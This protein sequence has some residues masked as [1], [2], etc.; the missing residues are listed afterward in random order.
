[1]AEMSDADVFGT[2]SSGS[3]PRM[4]NDAE[5][6]GPAPPVPMSD[7]AVGLSS[8]PGY[9]DYLGEVGKS[10]ARGVVEAAVASP[11]RGYAGMHTEEALRAPAERQIAL[12]QLMAGRDIDE[13]VV[14][15]R[16]TAQ[17][18][19]ATEHPLY[20]TA[21]T[22]SG[23]LPK[24]KG[25]LNP[26]VRDVASGFGSVAGNIG[27]MMIPGYNLLGIP[28]VVAQGAGEA[29]ERAVKANAT[30]EQIQRAASFGNI[31]GATEFADALLINSG[32]WGRAASLVGRVGMRALKGAFIEGGQEGLQQFIQNVIAQQIYKPEQKWSEDVAYNAMIG[33]IVGG[34]VAAPGLGGQTPQTPVSQPTAID[35][36][37]PPGLDPRMPQPGA[38][39][40]TM[41][42]AG[43]PI[44]PP[45][46]IPLTPTAEEVKTQ[47]L[48]PEIVIHIQEEALKVPSPQ[49]LPD[50]DKLI[51]RQ[52]EDA[53]LG[54]EP[55]MARVQ[56]SPGANTARLAKLLGPKLYG[57]PSNITAVS[58]KEMFQ[59]SFDAVKASLEGKALTDGKID[60]TMDRT[61][62]SIGITD[63]GAGM[64]PEVL[65]NQFLQIA[66]TH[67]E[68]KRASGGLGI[69]KMLFI[70]GNKNLHVTT[71]RN[72]T[73]SELNT[74]G[75]EL[76]SALDD[77]KKAPQ[78]T[79][80]KPTSQD[81]LL[82]PNGHGT[83]VEVT[84]PSKYLDS[85]TGEDKEIGF[86][87][88]SFQH[89]VLK[90]SPLFDNID[91]T[92]NGE[93][94][95]MGK[96]FPIED[97]TQF[98]NVKFDWGTA[99]IYVSQKSSANKYQENV[100]V[101]SNGLW[102]FSGDI[103]KD[104]SKG[105]YSENIERDIYVDINS[106]VLPEESGYPF[107]LNRQGFSPSTRKAFD[108][109]FKYIG[110]VYRQADIQKSV[111]NFGSMQFL[112]YDAPGK[113]VKA[114]QTV[115]IEPK[116]PP[117][118]T[119][120]T[121]I[122]P[123][124]KVSV[125]DG[126]LVVNGR[127]VPEL[128]PDEI[129]KFK[130]DPD[131]LRVPQ[132]EIDPRRVILHDNTDVVVSAL[133]TRSITDHGRERFGQRF[134]E[135]AFALG[136][137]FKELRDVVV[138]YMPKVG[139]KGPV[140]QKDALNAVNNL[141]EQ[142]F[143]VKMINGYEELAKEGVGIS[144]DKQ[145][146][147]VSITVPFRAM[148]LN[149][150]IADRTDPLG[151]AV[152]MSMT[153]VHE[154]THHVVRNHGAEFV[155]E[156]QRVLVMLETNP[157][158]NF[159][160]FKQKMVNILTAYHDVFSHLRAVYTSGD[161]EIVNRGQRF[162]DANA[163]AVIRSGLGGV[164]DF[165]AN[166]A[167]NGNPL[168]NVTEPGSQPER[169][170][171]LSDWVAESAAVPE[172]RPG[173]GEPS[174][175]LGSS[176]SHRGSDNGRD[177]NYGALRGVDPGISA[178]PQQPDLDPIRS[179]V[180]TVLGGTSTPEVKEAA[181]HA[182]RYNWFYKMFAGITQ[183]LDSNPYFQPLRKYTERGRMMHSDESK[184]WD[185]GLRTLKDW[186]SL[187]TQAK[188]L[189]ALIWD[190]QAMPYLSPGEKKMH[191]WRHPSAVEFN[192]LVAKH[193]LS[194]DAV[195]MYNRIRQ[196]DET[197][198]QLLEQEMIA[199]AKRKITDPVKLV[200]R[201][202]EIE[203]VGRMARAQ[204]YFPFTRFGRYYLTVKDA[205][206]KVIHFETF[207]PRRLFGVTTKRAEKYQMA[208]KRI[209]EKRVPPGHTV[210]EG[211]LPETAE[212]LAGLPPI[213]LQE[214]IAEGTSFT[215]AQLEAIKLMQST[216]NPAL[217]LNQRAM[218]GDRSVT[219]ASLDL[220]RAFAKHYF[221]AGRYYA[222]LA[223]VWALKAHIAEAQSVPGNKAGLIA[224]HM[225]DH[226]DNTILDAKGDFGFWKGAIFLWAMGYVPAAAT[227]NMVQTPMVTLPFLAAKFGDFRASGRIIQAMTD[228][229]NFY[230]RG[231][232]EGMT[233]F[234]MRA[235]SYGIKTGRISETQAAELAGLASGGT[236]VSGMGGTKAQQAAVHFQEKAAWM[237]EMAEQWNR[238]IAFRAALKLA[239]G[240]P[241]AKFVNE[242][243]TKYE[244]EYKLLLAGSKDMPPLNESEARA[245][246]TAIATVD[247]TQFVY[248]KYARSRLFRGKMS[249]ILVFKQYIS[250]L[251]WMLGGNK[252]D[253]L[254]R[255]LILAVL[256]GGLGGVPGYD[257]MRDIFRAIGKW[258]FGKD[259]NLD[260]LIRDYV[261]Q[262]FGKDSVLQ[263][264]LVLH[265]LARRGFGLP[266]IADAMG[267]FVTG[268]PGRGLGP[269]HSSNVPL[270]ILDR[271]RAITTGNILPFSIGKLMEP[272][273]KI[274]RTIADQ[275]QKASGAAFSVGFNLYKAVMDQD[276]PA[277]DFKRWEKAMPRA[278]SSTSR[279]YR[280][281]TEGRERGAKGGPNSAA[282]IVPYDV[283]DTE[284][285]MEA[286]ALAGGYQP[287]RQQAKWDFIIAQAE[288][289]AFHK[290]QK[291]KLL[292]EY[293][294]A[295][296]G[297]NPD[298]VG[299][300]RDAII[301]YNREL[302]DFAR[303]T[304]ISGDTIQRSMQGRARAL[305]ARESGIPTQ[306]SN[307]GISL[308]MQRLFPEATID[309][310]R[311]R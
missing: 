241:T 293:F 295:L 195:A 176:R 69:A 61:T 47:T 269:G 212:H 183:L 187:G 70:F 21:E 178:P 204:P 283:R 221:Y 153:M 79:T 255:F 211:V 286:L 235:L 98:A 93:P 141:V 32:S 284:Q 169:G 265:G 3:A 66:G 156:M 68:S 248:S 170:S 2:P 152:D 179:G 304:A 49:E 155:N 268:T 276:S 130:I 99:R 64:T 114:S 147:G 224:S 168:G 174:Y 215:E 80:R 210:E 258:F 267:S 253:V 96:L 175:T 227:Q 8:A 188:N 307:I 151:A 259:A 196:M 231:T 100:H 101:L 1:M 222:K 256:M 119:A 161:F 162:E 246:I 260:H 72:G 244:G 240:N 129:A 12:E 250:S 37:A 270:P 7:E 245:V 20:Q 301:R 117:P 249:I 86:K 121:L 105:Q 127:Q 34:G 53:A 262:W 290:L 54:L 200:K 63:N 89:T 203:S 236:L 282:T 132:S 173:R 280:A 144:F 36:T 23:A 223:H 171:R 243:V 94:L 11:M 136:N 274:D 24:D 40:I 111:A 165:G 28:N 82:F 266:G 126:Q 199:S 288:V 102:Q 247:Q 233:D 206:G 164:E 87:D 59:N 75:E 294:E 205:A 9:T 254:P 278:L 289:T 118:P 172:A 154:L 91:V 81:S 279:S 163:S 146:Y 112:D 234:D 252:G 185:A 83:H 225:K 42:E 310:R 58:V 60:I 201:I 228:M 207:E 17:P 116:A 4:M 285:F 216:R 238:R 109:L 18:V 77:A 275:T 29:T 76:F 186:R 181:A 90:Q 251:L 273:E 292:G 125:V 13:A 298:E 242:S 264:D 302:P 202:E 194:A 297:K 107:D 135:Y 138:R 300:V 122:R 143:G 159:H 30:P 43:V 131:S 308:E 157:N 217:A 25:V 309:V 16:Q 41:P 237:F 74:T 142:S 110:L 85:Q 158:F 92:F 22:I 78:I 218:Y 261:L 184:I 123:G 38:P 51:Q 145:Y 305:N 71:M 306:K 139:D 95:E 192:A 226:L 33:A 50:F 213:L 52:E 220:P 19:P 35:P 57:E 291:D 148:F 311:V 26:V 10:F 160:A 190:I 84:V 166:E 140:G 14:T 48:A 128:T 67:K 15:A 180:R 56:T 277:G 299:K 193:K 31:S 209:L 65:G 120:A 137:A 108:N 177:A 44:T 104:P 229:K 197:Y 5:V 133:E 271:S 150:A 230:R 263:P 115:K 167:G 189:E 257:D 182:D 191:L 239:Q 88:Y 149:V 208:Q 6:F 287:L 27:S 39:P 62:R 198:L 272:T 113:T 124:D 97:Y 303:G 106:K 232:Y 219:G 214:L 55:K 134:D 281:F 46:E 73:V 103:K 45:V 296:K